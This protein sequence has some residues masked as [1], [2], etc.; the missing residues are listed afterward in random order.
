MAG[1]EFYKRLKI[2]GMI[3]FIPVILAGGPLAGYFAG[4]Y[5]EKKF[6]LEPLVTYVAIGLGLV[7]S[8]IEVVKII[9]RVVRIDAR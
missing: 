8:M 5:L 7:T 2:A 3:S 9:R 6:G 1:G 4:S